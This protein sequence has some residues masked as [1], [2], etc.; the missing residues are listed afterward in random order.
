MHDCPN[1]FLLGI[2][3]PS[4]SRKNHNDLI[5]TETNLLHNTE[6]FCS[7]LRLKLKKITM[8][9]YYEMSPNLNVNLV[10][11]ITYLHRVISILNTRHQYFLI[12]TA[13]E[14]LENK[15]TSFNNIFH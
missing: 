11:K 13:K 3:Y 12:Q 9:V 4:F 8:A 2:K 10:I 15:Q 1:L 6:T 7:S 14:Q 5:G